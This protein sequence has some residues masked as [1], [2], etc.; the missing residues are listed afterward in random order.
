[1][2]KATDVAGWPIHHNAGSYSS[3]LCARHTAPVAYFSVG[4]I[5]EI[6]RREIMAST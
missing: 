5:L 3:F 6:I 2:A 4:E 1:M